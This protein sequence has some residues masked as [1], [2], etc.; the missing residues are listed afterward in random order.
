MAIRSTGTF[1][2]FNVFYRNLEKKEIAAILK[3]I[4]QLPQ[5]SARVDN[6]EH[7][8]DI[9]HK[10]FKF[11]YSSYCFHCIIL[12]VFFVFCP[13]FD[14][15]SEVQQVHKGTNLLQNYKSISS[16]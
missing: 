4:D 14:T 9:N 16:L 7:S 12:F 1:L 6:F 5:N 11:I 8:F 15:L 10:N 3:Y 2:I 13:N